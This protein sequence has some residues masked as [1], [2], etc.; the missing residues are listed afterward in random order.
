MFDADLSTVGMFRICR[1]TLGPIPYP[2][3]GA[4]SQPAHCQLA[5]ARLPRSGVPPPLSQCRA[6]VRGAGAGVIAEPLHVERVARSCLASVR[7]QRSVCCEHRPCRCYGLGGFWLILE[8][9]ETNEAAGAASDRET[10]VQVRF[11]WHSWAFQPLRNA[12]GTADPRFE[13]CFGP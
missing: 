13:G 12:S 7:H 1:S 6:L 5:P 10:E 2:S 11:F 4:R 8:H 9:H 3:A